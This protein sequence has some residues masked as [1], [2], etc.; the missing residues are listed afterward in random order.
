MSRTSARKTSRKKK[1]TSNEAVITVTQEQY[2]RDRARGLTDDELLHP[3]K[4][5]FVRGGFLK[6]HPELDPRR[7]PHKEQVTI[8][9]DSDV[10]KFFRGQ[11]AVTNSMNWASQINQALREMMQ[12]AQNGSAL[13]PAV[14]ALVD[15][16]RFL[17]AVA[18]RLASRGAARGKTRRKPKA[19]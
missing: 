7:E 14:A 10:L 6:R 2:K 16:P 4:H 13:P 9:L 17:N 19:A 12:Q 18:E 15:D 8:W 3:G 11:A 1:Q 5:R